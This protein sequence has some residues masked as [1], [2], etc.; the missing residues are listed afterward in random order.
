MSKRLGSLL[1]DYCRFPL[2]ILVA[3]FVAR[4]GGCF[5]WLEAEP[6]WL[7]DYL[8]NDI[9]IYIYRVIFFAVRKKIFVIEQTSKK[10]VNRY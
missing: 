7:E 2:F 4:N 10:S 9:Y 8:Q 5:T 6:H 1:C 3:Q